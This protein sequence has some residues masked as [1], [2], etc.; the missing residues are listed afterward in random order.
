MRGIGLQLKA[1]PLQQLHR[2]IKYVWWTPILFGCL[3]NWIPHL[4][5]CYCTNILRRAGFPEP[6]A[7][8]FNWFF[9]LSLVA[10]GFYVRSSLLTMVTPAERVFSVGVMAVMAVT[11]YMFIDTV[12]EIFI[13][14]QVIPS[15]WRGIRTTAKVVLATEAVLGLGVLFQATTFRADPV[16]FIFGGTVLVYVLGW[17]ALLWQ[18]HTATKASE[19]L[20]EDR[21]AIGTIIPGN[22]ELS[23]TPSGDPLKPF[24]IQFSL[25]TIFVLMLVAAFS[26]QL[27]NQPLPISK[28]GSNSTSNANGSFRLH[29]AGAGEEAYIAILERSAEPFE[30]MNSAQFGRS[31][32]KLHGVKINSHRNSQLYLYDCETAEFK[33]LK[34]EGTAMRD[35]M[36]MDAAKFWMK[37][38]EPQV[39]SE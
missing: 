24:N 32:L 8:R 30:D 15:I 38:V 11:R 28:R 39:E 2:V 19:Y 18:L 9:Y 20:V 17:I 34:T 29:Y 14:E 23:G 12:C 5:L 26:V 22:N 25:G 6:Y 36:D 13:R 10:L 31:Y 35:A 7:K 16:A 3:P 4:I 21:V 37:H 27:W 1:H 33:R